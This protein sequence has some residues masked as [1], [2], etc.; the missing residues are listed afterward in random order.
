MWFRTPITSAV[1][2]PFLSLSSAF[3]LQECQGLEGSQKPTLVQHDYPSFYIDLEAGNSHLTLFILQVR[4]VK[5]RE[6]MELSVCCTAT[7]AGMSGSFCLHKVLLRQGGWPE[8]KAPHF[9]PPRR[10][11][12]E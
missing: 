2:F 8:S 5:L 6:R 1:M 4:K 11:L 3:L 10:L 9:P 12:V 7:K